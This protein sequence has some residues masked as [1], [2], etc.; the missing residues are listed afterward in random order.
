MHERVYITHACSFLLKRIGFDS[1][2]LHC[3]THM[4][5]SLSIFVSERQWPYEFMLDK[6]KKKIQPFS[7]SFSF[8]FWSKTFVWYFEIMMNTNEFMVLV[9][10]LSDTLLQE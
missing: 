4:A 6:L 9:L 5:A 10:L 7:F 1:A 8:S 2:P 3:H